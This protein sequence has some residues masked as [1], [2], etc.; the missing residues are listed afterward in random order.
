MGLL[1]DAGA[2][3]RRR[4]V[5]DEGDPL[6]HGI[7]HHQVGDRGDRA[8]GR[9]QP[10]RTCGARS[11]TAPAIDHIVTVRPQDLEITREGNSVVIA[12]AYRKEIPLFTGVGLYIDYAAELER[13]VE[14]LGHTF[15]DARLL[16]RALTHRSH[17]CGPQRAA[18]IPR[19]RRPRLRGRRRAL[20]PLPAASRR[21]ADPAA[22]E[23]GARGV[24]RRRWRASSAWRIW[25]APG[26]PPVPPSVL[27]DA[28]EAVF[29]AIFLDG[30][31]A[32][33]RARGGAGA[34]RAA[35]AA[36]PGA[37]GEGRQD[38]ACRSCCTRAASAC[39]STAWWPRTARRT[40][41]PST[42]NARSGDLRQHRAR[43]TSRQRAE[44]EAAKAM[45]DKL[46][47]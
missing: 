21:Q 11:R 22:R 14:L 26:T 15:A 42:W 25:C 45:L 9:D 10:G 20:R 19:R 41:A 39:P 6:V 8:P 43:G 36:R 7:P 17:G 12:F 47:A 4:A 35:R 5:R 34:R 31:Y 32:A 2:V 37:G 18:G 28:L 1:I 29:G 46:Q 44:Q 3:H 13:P 38:R 40:S 24:P 30:G 33:A 16:E 27:A 23:P